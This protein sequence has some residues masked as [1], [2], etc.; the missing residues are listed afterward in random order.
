[1][2]IYIHTC[3]SSLLSTISHS[4]AVQASFVIHSVPSRTEM[5]CSAAHASYVPSVG[6]GETVGSVNSV[7]GVGAVE[8]SSG[9]GGLQEVRSRMIL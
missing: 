8:R 9:S 1:M 4:S 7:T 3:I 5:D 6:V 2:Y